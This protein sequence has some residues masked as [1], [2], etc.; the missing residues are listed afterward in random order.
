[1]K[2]S[3]VYVH[4]MDRENAGAAADIVAKVVR[5]FGDPGLTA[6]DRSGAGARLA[7]I[8]VFDGCA[9]ELDIVLEGVAYAL[10][11]TGLATT[12]C[13]CCGLCDR[14]SDFSECQ[15]RSTRTSE[16]V[17]KWVMDE[18]AKRYLGEEAP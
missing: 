5:D 2:Q 1:M 16:R 12:E 18:W 14:A 8:I 3:R 15:M 10:E 13:M 17:P 6:E 4:A 11:N 7:A 9:A